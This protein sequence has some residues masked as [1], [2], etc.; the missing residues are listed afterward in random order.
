MATSERRCCAARGSAAASASGARPAAPADEEADQDAGRHLH[1]ERGVAEQ[2]ERRALAP[3][4]D[5]RVSRTASRNEPWPKATV[6]RGLELLVLEG[7]TVS[8]ANEQHSGR[9]ASA[10][11]RED[12]AE[13]DQREQRAVA[14]RGAARAGAKPSTA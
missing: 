9:N 12:E 1:E 13:A 4:E 8:V 5:P 14:A 3:G 7:A 6:V 11:G 2:A 10:S